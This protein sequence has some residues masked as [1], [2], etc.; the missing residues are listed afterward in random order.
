MGILRER[1]LIARE[2]FNILQNENDL[3]TFMH[4]RS[5]YVSLYENAQRRQHSTKINGGKI[6]FHGHVQN[7]QIQ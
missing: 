7:T 4:F 3:I 5:K 6:T 1:A 2:S